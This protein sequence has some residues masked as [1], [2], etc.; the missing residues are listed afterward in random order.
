M[1]KKLKIGLVV[2][3]ATDDIPLEGPMMYPD[4]E[5][6][7]KGVGVRSLTPEGYDAAWNGIL[8]AAEYVA[9]QG[10]DAI[11]VIGTSLTF[12]RGYDA[13]Q[14][15]MQQL[16]EKTGLPVSTMSEAVVHGLQ[17]V[18]AKKIAVATAYADEVNDRLADFLTRA[19]FEVLA[20]KGFGLFGFGEPGKKSEK[21]I[22]ELS[23]NAID[24]A[25]KA[26][27]KADAVL[28]SCGGLLTLNCAE[29]IEQKY[30]IPVVT[31]TQSSFWKAMGL[32][33]DKGFVAD[34]GKMLQKSAAATV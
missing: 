9:K 33:G 1:S 21:D 23:G 11:M 17:A 18:G 10:V 8:P 12:Y 27:Q 26:D 31:S 16:R 28:I 14:T 34:K 3:F 13:H 24:E 19:G 25:K 6:V 15:L 4:V 5:F 2:P 30:G 29:P 22:I 7:A 20:L 32:A